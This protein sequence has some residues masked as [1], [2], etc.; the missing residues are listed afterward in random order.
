MPRFTYS[1]IDREGALVKGDISAPDDL[2]AM[3]Q[4]ARQGLT[5]VSLDEGGSAEPW[6][7]RDIRLFGNSAHLKKDDQARFFATL[8]TMLSSGFTL[9]RALTFAANQMK[10]GR[11][12]RVASALADHV[13]AGGTLADA[14]A[15]S[16]AFPDRLIGLI[17]IGERANRLTEVTQSIADML[18][19]E[20]RNAQQVR[21]ALIYPTILLVMSVLVVLMLVF[22]LAPTLVPV[23]RSAGA[24][25]PGLLA[26]LD[27]IGTYLRAEW[28]TSL[29]GLGA[30]ALALLVFRA[31]LAARFGALIRRLP[32]I[33]SYATARETL[34]FLQTLHL[35]LAS[36]AQVPL[37]LGTTAE[38]AA[39]ARW[40]DGIE[41]MRTKV[42]AGETLTVALREAGLADDRALAFVEAGE[43]GDRLAQMLA[44]GAALLDDATTNQ[45]SQ[46]LR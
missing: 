22:F 6:W 26:T 21:Q 43:E 24:E 41:D 44:Q 13:S 29:V 8:R 20:I 38:T 5:P 4:L 39:T 33:R 2:A 7:Q 28:M 27:G 11:E 37:A 31:P 15:D 30:M 40:R 36:G 34:R 46:I 45:L 23:F 35:M 18:N 25:P 12:K 16:G 10:G 42:E 32:G 1:A 19:T 3:D 9:I 14:L 17:Q